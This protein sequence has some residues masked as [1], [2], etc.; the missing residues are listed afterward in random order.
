MPIDLVNPVLVTPA[1]SCDRQIITGFEVHERDARTGQVLAV[2]ILII[3]W[4][5]LKQGNPD[6]IASTGRHVVNPVTI[7]GEFP[8]PGK[9]RRIDL[10]DRLYKL[11]VDD[12]VFMLGPIT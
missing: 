7:A 12:G 6:I 1:L 11:L 9:L 5:K 10:R 4:V 2:P 3:Y 8:A